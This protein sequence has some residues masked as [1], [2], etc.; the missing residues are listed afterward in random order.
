MS[1]KNKY[2]DFEKNKLGGR[3]KLLESQTLNPDQQKLY[4]YLIATKVSWA[5]QNHFAGALEDGRLIGP[6]NAFLYSPKMARAF[7][8]WIDAESADSSLS[9]TVRQLIIL[10]VGASWNATYEIY[11]H[12]AVGKNAGLTDAVLD[13]IK[14]HL[15]PAKLTAEEAAAYKFTSSLVNKKNVQD[16]L[17]S[18]TT[19]LLT[20][21]GVADMV[22]LIGLYMAVSALLN[23]FEIPAPQAETL[24]V[25]EES[26]P[27]IAA[28][29]APAAA[30]VKLPKA[31]KV[32]AVDLADT[33]TPYEVT[34]KVPKAAAPK[35]P[36]AAAAPK[37]PKAVAAPKAPK[38]APAPKAPKAA[39]APKAPKEEKVAAP[40]VTKAEKITAPKKPKAAKSVDSE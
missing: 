20:E 2:K 22:N 5:K 27:E 15:L 36:K 18:E 28:V 24:E 33:E 35:A 30:S 1:V 40:K 34:V 37:A 7:N 23:A 13:S 26:A 14:A 39:A 25:Q 38:A 11:A 8:D 21:K 4:D 6:F 17:Y 3:L 19:A 31:E 29:N 12:E 16:E 10:T 9:P 32:P